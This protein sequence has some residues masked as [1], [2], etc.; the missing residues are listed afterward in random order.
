LSFA[1]VEE[2]SRAL[3]LALHQVG[4]TAGGRVAV[5]TADPVDFYLAAASCY[6]GGFALIPIDPTSGRTDLA[7]ILR[8]TQPAVLIA[9][10]PVMERL[11]PDRANILWRSGTSRQDAPK[12]RS[13]RWYFRRPAVPLPSMDALTRTEGDWESPAFGD[14]LPAFIICTSGTTSRSKATVQSRGAL[15]AHVET[16]ARVFGY[17]ADARFLNL[18]PT[19]HVDGLVHGVYASLMT[20]MTNLQP[21]LFTVDLDIAELLRRSG[22]THFVSNPNMLAIIRRS[23][24]DRPD[25]FR[26]GSFLMLASSAGMLEVGFWKEFQEFFGIRL[27][28]FYGLTETV[29]GSIYCGPA[30]ETFR[31]GTLGKPLDTRARLVDAAG[32][33]V[34]PGEPGELLIAG[35]HL[36]TGYLDDPEATTATLR[37]GWLATGD[38]CVAD[39]DGFFTMVGRSKTVI[40][41]GGTTIHPEDIRRVIATMPGVREVEVLGLPDETFE[42]ALV[43]CVVAQEGVTAADIRACCAAEL[44]A[45]RRPDR[46]ELFDALP[47]GS[48]G[49]VRRE[50]LVAMVAQRRA[51]AAAAAPADPGDLTESVLTLAAETFQVAL[52]DLTLGSGPETVDGW[53]SFSHM[54]FVLGLEQRFAIRLRA[55]QIMQLGSIGDAVEIVGAQ[56]R[57]PTR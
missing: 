35:P 23:F 22:A 45:E 55:K 1:E 52:A 14:D 10:E 41:R 2:R 11:G 15:R 51:A 7:D 34:S 36:M 38:I 29:S 13:G 18:L 39:A 25:L 31:L 40:M 26:T 54:E 46:V 37:D 30:D 4:C 19:H 49:K 8:S 9:D 53:D 21:G 56:R 33:E 17:D 5:A 24:G 3:A 12:S 47:L 32:E 43:A 57:A 50:A 44:A 6:L 42:E 48:V 27:N 28:N 16:L 20:G